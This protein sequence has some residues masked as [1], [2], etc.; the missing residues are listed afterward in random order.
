MLKGFKN[1]ILRGNVVDLAVGVVIGAS[2]STVVSS[3]VKDILTP[4]I[5]AIA[6]VPDFS[7]LNFTL[8][9]SRFMYGSFI[10]AVISFLLVAAAIYFFVVLPMNKV[11]EKMKKGETPAEA[12]ADIKLLSEIRDLLKK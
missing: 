6:K 3:L 8:N 7:G 1:F 9:H 4:L 2:F 12:P 5:G 10:N 11:M